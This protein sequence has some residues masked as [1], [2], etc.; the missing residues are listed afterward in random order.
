M[1]IYYTRQ[2]RG[3]ENIMKFE[4]IK[5]GISGIYK[6]VFNNNKIYIGLRFKRTSGITNK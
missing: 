4:E 2:S 6:I 1:L 5:Y 3:K